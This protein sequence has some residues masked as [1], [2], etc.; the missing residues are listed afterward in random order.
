MFISLKKAA[1]MLGV[2]S[3]TVRRW[4]DDGKL[5]LIRSVGGHRRV[6]LEDVKALRR[7]WANYDHI[8]GQ[9]KKE[10]EK[11]DPLGIQLLGGSDP[12]GLED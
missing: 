6:M 1:N 12:F 5:R 7:R 3:S 10:E 11:K 2:T 9:L 4:A 8:T